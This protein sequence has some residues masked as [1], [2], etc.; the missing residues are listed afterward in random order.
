M[1]QYAFSNVMDVRIGGAKLP[2]D[3]ARAL[4]DGWVDQGVGVPAAFRLTFRDTYRKLL[5]KLEHQLR[6]QGGDR[7]GRPTARAPPIRC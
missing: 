4:V 7:A 2:S 5:G 1:V 6:H 3:A